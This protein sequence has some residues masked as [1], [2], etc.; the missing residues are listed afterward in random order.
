MTVADIINEYDD[1]RVNTVDEQR[2][3][4]W[5]MAVERKVF[6]D[7]LRKYDGHRDSEPQDDEMWIDETGSLHLPRNMYVDENMNLVM[8]SFEKIPLPSFV[9]RNSDGTVTVDDM[10]ASEFG[11]NSELSIPEPY[12]DIYLHY[13]D[14]KIAY[15]N[16][17]AKTYN[18]ASQE[19]NN[20]YLA[21]QQLFNRTHTPDRPR[22]HLIR[23]EVL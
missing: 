14:L 21:Y 5:I 22:G 6:V 23:H 18:I 12:T 3:V 8:D 15:Y 16:N 10:D 1:L 13:L 7:I 4:R 2:K 19:F 20:E 11:M 9:Y 17:D